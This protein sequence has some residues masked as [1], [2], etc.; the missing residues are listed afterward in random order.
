MDP[1]VNLE[2]IGIPGFD[3][4]GEGA[5]TVRI[6]R[7]LGGMADDRSLL[8]GI[9]LAGVREITIVM[10]TDCGGCLA[11]EN[12]DVIADNL[13][14]RLSADRFAVF[15]SEIGE[16]FRDNLRHYLKAFQRPEEALEREISRIR[17]LPFIPQELIIHGVI[18]EL[19]SGNIQVLVNGY[20]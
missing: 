18:Y 17:Q 2:A 4:N 13:R 12:I 7:T 11:Y 8:V 5:S 10:H 20:T 3:Q 16:P 19:A 15:Q 14:N 1:R 6:I 9:F